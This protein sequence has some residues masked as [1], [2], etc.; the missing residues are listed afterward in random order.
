MSVLLTRRRLSTAAALRELEGAGLGGVVFFAGRVRPDRKREGAV[1]AIEYEAHHEVAKAALERLES[2][3]RRSYGAERVVA[4]HR[5][6]RVPVNDVA[7]I[8]GA[9]TG[10][11]AEAFAATRFLIE[12]LKATVPIWKAETRRSA[13][14]PRRR[15]GARAGRSAG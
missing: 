3:A 4:W 10:H 12:E 11:R 6:G 5:L 13:R 8:V 7:V 14:R 2:R 9:A 1:V 15:P